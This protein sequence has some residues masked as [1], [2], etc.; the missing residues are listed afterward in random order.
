MDPAGPTDFP[1][2]F[3]ITYPMGAPQTIS[4][5]LDL[6][7]PPQVRPLRA[8][9]HPYL[10]ADGRHSVRENDLFLES[11]VPAILSAITQEFCMAP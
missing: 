11:A 6:E 4:M 8:K 2:A 7:S 9:S 5:S 10:D 1:M 3:A